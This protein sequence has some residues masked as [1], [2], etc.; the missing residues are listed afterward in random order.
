M[1]TLMAVLRGSRP[2]GPRSGLRDHL[3][4]R[5]RSLRALLIERNGCV[6]PLFGRSYGLDR[7]DALTAGHEVAV[8]GY[9]IADALT[10]E[11]RARLDLLAV[12][13][14][15]PSGTLRRVEQ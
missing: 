9:E 2:Q 1:G 10:R 3:Q 12:Y 15:S 11:D 14:L 13:A 5:L 4:D 7:L 6:D 8:L